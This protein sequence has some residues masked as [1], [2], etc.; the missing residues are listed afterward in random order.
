MG[1]RA[2]TGAISE[3]RLADGRMHFHVLGKTAPRGICGSG[4][5]D[6]IAAGL[7]LGAIGRSGR[8]S[9]SQSLELAAP[10]SLT[11]RDIRELQLAKGALAA[12][13]RLLLDYWGASREQ[14]GQVF[15]A[16]AFGNYIN[17]SNARRIGLFKF[18]SES[19]VPA[20][21]TA[22]LGAKL[23]LFDLA[24]TDMSYPNLIARTTHVSLSELPGFQDV[25]AEEMIFP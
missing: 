25:Y 22:L 10:V 19:V 16:G 6:A 17:Q 1:M 23:A 8:L 18:P 11:Q 14:I 3:V 9:K 13:V 21:N 15:L 20:G 5:V 7:E 12:G 2:A 24:E 4:L